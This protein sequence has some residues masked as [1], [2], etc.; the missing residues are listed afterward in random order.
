MSDSKKLQDYTL[1]PYYTF[2]KGDL[3]RVK[4]FEVKLAGQIGLIISK[5]DYNTSCIVLF[6]NGIKKKMMK[7]SLERVEEHS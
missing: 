7:F 4:Q 1:K 6:P 3:V 5:E 2:K